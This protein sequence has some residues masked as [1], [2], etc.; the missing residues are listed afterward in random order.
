MALIS[1]SANNINFPQIAERYKNTAVQVLV[2]ETNINTL[3]SRLN[4]SPNCYTKYVAG[5]NM[6]GETG[7]IIIIIIMETNYCIEMNRTPKT[8]RQNE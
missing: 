4:A 1:F 3:I 8:R 5:A 7:I 6:A 2:L